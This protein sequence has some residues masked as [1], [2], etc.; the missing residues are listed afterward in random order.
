[1]EHQ[2]VFG[3]F[4]NALL[5]LTRQTDYTGWYNQHSVLGIIFADIHDGH[6]EAVRDAL[7]QKI[8]KALE[9]T[10]LSPALHSKIRV[11]LYSFP[12]P[13]S[14]CSAGDLSN[15]PFYRDSLRDIA[16]SRSYRLLK[17]SLDMF[18]GIACLIVLSPVFVVIADAI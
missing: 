7:A 8:E 5:Q 12:D 4:W 14:G 18:V 3:T 10:K 6:S 2:H 16:C 17:R 9:A 15:L 13:R 1:P 11:R